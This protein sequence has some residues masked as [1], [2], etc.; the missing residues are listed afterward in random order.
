MLFGTLSV[1]AQDSMYVCKGY[2]YL[3]VGLEDI[4]SIIF[5]QPQHMTPSSGYWDEAERLSTRLK[6]TVKTDTILVRVHLNQYEDLIEEYVKYD[7]DNY[8]P[9]ATYIGQ[10]GDSDAVVMKNKIHVTMD[11]TAP[12]FNAHTVPWHLFMQ[13][14][15]CI[16]RLMSVGHSLTGDD[17]GSVWKDEIDREYTLG[18]ISGNY[19]YMLP[20]VRKTEKPLTRLSM[21]TGCW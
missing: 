19:L 17:I 8:T 20:T 3:S 18:W 5:Y 9:N 11:S 21:L 16:P 7:N 4:D 1:Q 10:T 2:R 6:V 15:Y 12:I 14:G 13:H